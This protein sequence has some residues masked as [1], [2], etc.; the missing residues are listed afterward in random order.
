MSLIYL[1]DST[2]TDK[3]TSHS[4]LDVYEELLSP[5]KHSAKNVLEVGIGFGGSIKLW[6]DFFPNA[7]VYGID[8]LPIDEIWDEL[9][10]HN[11]IILYTSTNAY[12]ETFFNDTFVSVNKRFDLMIDDGPHSLESMIQFIKL[13][14]QLMTDDGILIIEDVQFYDW[15]EP[16]KNAVPIELAKFIKVFD[17]RHVKNRWDD[18]I[19]VIDKQL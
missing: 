5:K 1:A 14:S 13:Y 19:F 12:D 10:L 15:I 4:Y 18:I 16:L 3:N 9:K 7:I 17:L 6:S 2:R 8:I 11:K